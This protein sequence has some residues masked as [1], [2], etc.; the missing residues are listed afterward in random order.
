MNQRYQV[1]PSLF[2]ASSMVLMGCSSGGSSGSSPAPA[3]NPTP[4]PPA[5]TPSMQVLPATYDFGKVT[6]TNR[7]A[8]LAVTIKNNGNGALVV[9]GIT[10]RAPADPSFLLSTNLGTNPCATVSPTVAPGASCTVQI[11]FLPSSSGSFNSTLQI[12]SND[13][14]SPNFGLPIVGV[15]EA[16]AALT[17]RINQV[18]TLA[19]ADPNA[20]RT[21][22]YVSVSDQGGYPV[23]GL[24]TNNFSVTQGPLNS[25]LGF[26]SPVTF[27]GIGAYKSVAI[28]GVL[29]FSKSLRD[30]PVA[31][32]DMKTGF[33][34]LF[35]SLKTG[36]EGE[37]VKFASE[38]EVVQSFTPN[39]TLLQNAISA[40]FDKGDGTR[41]YDAIYQAVED[42]AM[43]TTFRRAVIVATD[44]VENS[45]VAQTLNSVIA[46]AK[47][48]GVPIFAIGIGAAINSLDLGRLA[49][50]TG[51][52]YYQANASQ[53]L[54]SIYQQL[55]SLL[56]QNQYV[57]TFNRTVAGPDQSPIKVTANSGGATPGTDTKAIVA[58]P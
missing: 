43:K 7:P 24:Q 22:A 50:E 49:S 17:V 32:A 31:F 40:P 14:T 15:S 4:P 35:G 16:V 45:S 54:A 9:S 37:V 36:D 30:E 44:G 21:T 52:V 12:A 51:G 5:A 34:S 42:T 10:F 55:A 27:I 8:P 56:Y 3:P 29:D 46:N 19:C 23:L 39:R 28:A 1:L 33:S 57:L 6:A 13:P 41:L 53:N 26:V 2:L 18:D 25:V 47:A 11:E 38:F 48:K 58:C 20:M